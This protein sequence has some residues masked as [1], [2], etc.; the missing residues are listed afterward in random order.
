MLDAIT[1][2]VFGILNSIAN[3]FTGFILKTIAIFIPELILPLQKI[4]LFLNNYVWN[5]L[6]FVRRIFVNVLCFPNELFH[7]LINLLSLKLLLTYSA[8]AVLFCMN[9]FRLYRGQTTVSPIPNPQ[10]E[11]SEVGWDGWYKVE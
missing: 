2:F 10:I 6:F 4:S 1:K 11:A 9:L 8:R 7:F 3:L 5:I